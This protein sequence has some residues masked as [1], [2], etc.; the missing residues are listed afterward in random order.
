MADILTPVL[1]APAVPPLAEGI[2]DLERGFQYLLRGDF[3][4]AVVAWATWLQAHPKDQMAE[5]CAA[6][7]K[8]PRGCRG[9]VE[10]RDDG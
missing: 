7:S 2:D 3:D 1:A 4:S 5:R 9:L 6:D 8:P 10:A